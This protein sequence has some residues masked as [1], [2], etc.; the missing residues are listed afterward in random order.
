MVSDLYAYLNRVK[1][2]LEGKLFYDGEDKP[3]VLPSTE[4]HIWGRIIELG[5]IT[6]EVSLGWKANFYL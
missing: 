4:S 5:K 6:I 1:S 2:E 3:A